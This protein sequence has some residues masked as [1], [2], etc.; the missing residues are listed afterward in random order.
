M[1]TAARIDMR[2]DEETKALAERAAVALGCASLT[3]FMTRLIREHAPT[4]IE[5]E[6]NLQVT[7]Q[8]FDHFM[9]VCQDTERKPSAQI[10]DAA[11]RLEEEGF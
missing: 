4:I 5:H 2:I 10:L 9:R 6:T 8:Q 7:N 3:E 1:A 11:R